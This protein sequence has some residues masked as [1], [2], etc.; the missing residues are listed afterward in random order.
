[1]PLNML[2]ETINLAV[3]AG[4]SLKRLRSYLLAEEI[5]P[6]AVQTDLTNKN[7]PISVQITDGSF[8]WSTLVEE[9]ATATPTL[10]NINVKVRKMLR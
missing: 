4:V 3:N 6:N 5:D 8:K 2:P 10:Q 1:M 7:A 9:D